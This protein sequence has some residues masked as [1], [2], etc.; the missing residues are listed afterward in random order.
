MKARIL[1]FS[2]L[3]TVQ[4]LQGQMQ[5]GDW[6]INGKWSIQ[7]DVSPA[8]YNPNFSTSFQPQAGYFLFNG[9]AVG[10]EFIT[11][12]EKTPR[13]STET[14]LGALPF[15]RVYLDNRRIHSFLQIDGGW[16]WTHRHYREEFLLPDRSSRAS[17]LNL[18]L[19][20][21]IFLSK[22]VAFE[23]R[24]DYNAIYKRKSIGYTASDNI[25]MTIGFGLSYF[26][27]QGSMKEDTFNLPD[28]YL[29]AGNFGFGASGV[30]NFEEGVQGDLFWEKMLT[31]RLRLEIG[32]MNYVYYGGVKTLI[33]LPF[34]YFRQSFNIFIRCEKTRFFHLPEV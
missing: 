28:E 10:S 20:A 30:W 13:F 3:T 27:N 25:G 16:A 22:N 17:F 26:L 7:H 4:V 8:D 23:T 24:L 2:F 14:T 33:L 18:R 29:K 31:D 6:L 1:L 12:L 34:T 15:V 9:V 19:G 5:K 11:Q 32:S 21:G